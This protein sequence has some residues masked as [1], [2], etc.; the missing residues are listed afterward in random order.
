M[1]QNMPTER[2]CCERSLIEFL[3]PMD[4]ACMMEGINVL[5]ERYPFLSV[6][7]VGE[8]ILERGIPLLCLGEG[9]KSVL[10]VG[11]HRGREWMSS[12]I[13]L[14]MVNEYCEGMKNGDKILHYNLRYLFSSRTMYFVPMLNPDGVEYVLHGVEKDHILRE[15]LLSMNGGSEDFSSW[16]ANGRG[17]DLI[18]NYSADFA[19]RKAEELERGIFGGAPC[20]FSG[21]MPESEPEVAQL[22]NWLH[23]HGDISLVLS[24]GEGA[25]GIYGVPGESGAALARDA[26]CKLK[27][28]R[29][30]GLD[31]WCRDSLGISA[32]S[33]CYGTE[34]EIGSMKELFYHYARLRRT[35][36]LAPS[37]I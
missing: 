37:L 25:F 16:C 34:E 10:Y 9:E 36:F 35:L 21:E 13:L 6:S 4:H 2:I 5:S 20:G 32:F 27:D 17:V 33:V 12:A 3:Q 7:Y 23:Y 15:R 22:C 24:L 11:A 26:G 8:S 31:G 19:A 28:G 1:S 18:G 29:E 14:R 30:R